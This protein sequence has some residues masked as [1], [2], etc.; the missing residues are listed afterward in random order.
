M[1]L[2]YDGYFSGTIDEV[3]VYRTAL[4]DNQ[5][6]THYGAAYGASLPP[7]I[8]LEPVSV[9]NYVSLNASFLV[10][11]GGSVP[12]TYQW[13]KGNADLTDGGNLSG[14]TTEKLTIGP[15]TYADAG[16]YSVTIINPLGQTN[17]AVVTL[18]VLAP[19]ATTPDISGLA[20]H[21]P[22]DGNLVD[23]TG[24]GNNGTAIQ[25][26]GISSNV[27]SASSMFVSD[28]MLGRGLHFSTDYSAGTTNNTYVTLLDPQD[29]HFSSNVN[30]TVS[31][32]I[33]APMNY[34]Q[35]DLPLLLQ[36]CGFDVRQSRHRLHLY[37][38]VRHDALSRWMG[39][40]GVR[41]Q[42]QRRRRPRRDRLD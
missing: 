21:L 16:S 36:R 10:S 26:N 37:L 7:S 14:S 11:A 23:A 33:R 19:P 30:F 29:L 15:L 9:T 18:T 17:S 24:R 31:F 20:L 22:F 25:I 28:G 41:L 2:R 6:L 35:G 3:A 39:L 32:W 5:V 34:A 8:A 42:Q 12:R 1:T 4:S 27:V 40:V 38:W 13:K